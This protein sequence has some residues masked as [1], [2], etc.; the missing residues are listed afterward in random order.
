MMIEVRDLKKSFGPHRVLDGVS[1]SIAKGQ[2]VAVIGVSGPTCRAWA[3]KQGA[4]LDAYLQALAV[5]LA[6]K[7]DSDP[8][9]WT[10]PAKQL[11]EPWFASPRGR[12]LLFRHPGHHFFNEP[13]GIPCDCVNRITIGVVFYCQKLEVSQLVQVIFDEARLCDFNL[14]KVIDLQ[15]ELPSSKVYVEKVMST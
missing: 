15:D 10:W 9:E 1:F 7:L 12:V 3:M 8:P 2:A 5:Y 11:A 4:M 14:A 6:A 13:S